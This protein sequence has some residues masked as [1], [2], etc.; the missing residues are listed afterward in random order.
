[1]EEQNKIEEKRIQDFQVGDRIQ[2]F[3]II[4]A[5]EIR[6]N[7]NNKDYANLILGDQSGEIN[8]KIWDLNNVDISL[9]QE[10]VLIKVRGRVTEWQSQLQFNIEKIRRAKE[11]DGVFIRDFVQSAPY[12]SKWMY[13]EIVN[14]LDKIENQDIRMIA[15]YILE[16]KKEKLMYFPAAKSNHHAIRGGLLYHTLTMLRAGEK[17]LEVYTS[18]NKDLLFGGVILHDMAK[19]EEMDANELGIVNDYQVEG[20][21][22][23][24]IIQGIKQIN[25]VGNELGAD[26]EIIML[27]EHMVLSHHYE[28]EFGSP[29]KPLI[30]EAELL[31]YLDIID[32]R[33]YDMNTALSNT[34]KG[35]FSEKV[36]TLDNRRLYRAYLESIDK[37]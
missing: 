16:S 27:L 21:L 20:K 8:A 32:A 24:H 3:F 12:D 11:E 36:W 10:N 6:K 7:K 9:Y 2:N 26:P 25:Q 28:P 29:K 14:Y 15:E 18:L 19:I 34:K 22:L 33:L 1:M 30:P 4:K 5:L 17:L 35:E 23:G 13:Q 31:H 37:E